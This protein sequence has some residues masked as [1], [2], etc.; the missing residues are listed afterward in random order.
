MSCGDVVFMDEDEDMVQTVRVVGA[1]LVA[2]D[3]KRPR[4]CRAA[5]VMLGDALRYASSRL[6][7]PPAPCST[8]RVCIEAAKDLQEGEEVCVCGRAAF[9]GPNGYAFVEEV[10]ALPL[11]GQHGAEVL[12]SQLAQVRRCPLCASLDLDRLSE[13]G[14]D[15]LQKGSLKVVERSFVLDDGTASIRCEWRCCGC[16]SRDYPG[17]SASMDGRLAVVRG[18]VGSDYRGF[19]F[20]N[21]ASVRLASEEE[22]PLWTLLTPRVADGW[23]G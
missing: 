20:I 4:R 9:A 5:R 2:V 3:R 21:V 19:T 16:A 7:T 14:E 10:K 1:A 8:Y 22:A 13:I 23:D 18:S 12:R 17:E 11:Q 15:A 6:R